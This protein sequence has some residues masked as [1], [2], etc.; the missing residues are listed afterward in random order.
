MFSSLGSY[1][2]Y[3]LCSC[4]DNHT[5]V[6][7]S[8]HDTKEIFQLHFY[9]VFIELGVVSELDK[10]IDNSKPTPTNV[11]DQCKES[12]IQHMFTK[13]VSHGGF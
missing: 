9:F 1:H 10:E 12:T 8:Y 2:T 7:Y 4:H 5:Y 11:V 13:M 6:F 3:V